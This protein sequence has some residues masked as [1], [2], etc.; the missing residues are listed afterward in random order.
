MKPRF[1]GKP[2][3][4]ESFWSRAIPLKRGFT[5]LQ[6]TAYQKYDTFSCI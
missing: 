5:V 4:V 2:L 3:I 6:S 1:S